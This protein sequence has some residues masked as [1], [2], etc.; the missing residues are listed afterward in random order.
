MNIIHSPSLTLTFLGGD[1]EAGHPAVQTITEAHIAS[2]SI[3]FHQQ[4]LSGLKSASNQVDLLLD[5][6]CPAIEDI[7]ATEGDVKAVLVDGTET[8][9]TGY[10]ST[11]YNWML[12]HAGKQALAITIEDTG[13]RLF[14]KAFIESG[15]HLFNCTASE[16]IEAI[17]ARACITAS[18]DC[19]SLT[20]PVTRSVDGSVTCGELLDQLVYELGHVYFFDA[21]GQLRL[22]KVDCTSTEALPTLDKDDLVVVGGKAIT[23]SKKIRQ[24]KSAR[25]SFTRLGTANGYLVY[26]N[27]T[28]RGDGHPYCHLKL[29]GGSHFDGNEIYTESEW[30]EAQTDFFRTP[31]L[32]E[33]CNATS[34]I[35]IVGS[36]DIIAVSN[37]RTE[38]TAESG[39]ITADIAAAGGPYL[40]VTAHNSGTLTYHITRLD[41]YADIIYERDVNVVRTADSVY[42]GESSD[43]LLSEELLFVHDRTLAQAHA[44]LLGQFHRH[45]G[46]IYTFFSAVDLR[47][48]SLVRLI[49]DAFSGLNVSVLVTGRTFT[50]ESAAY[51]YEAVGISAFDLSAPAYLEV[52]DRGKNDT[53][54]SPG[55]PGSDGLSY[56]VSIQSSNGSVFRPEQ[57]DTILTCHVYQ[58]TTEITE[59]LDASRFR[60]KRL[61]TDPVDDGRWNT[62]SKAIAH[63][64]IEIKSTDCVGRTVFFCEIDLTGYEA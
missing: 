17:C 21:L 3:T 40:E 58:N 55:P 29:E 63:K 32:I 26:R 16:A 43:N 27:T 50:D 4:L 41:A 12:T 1:L 45:A 53:V 19:I 20:S 7:I 34:E 44:N 30:T 59:A 36:S 64:S 31:S 23:L 48:G 49:D 8:L 5:K 61:S 33:A 15:R 57:V 22:F 25:V 42:E 9:F 54:G 38:F 24:Y 35:D 13:T 37:V 56:T 2:R 51:R 52:L 39:Y 46:S 18:P 14:G 47:C 11:S 28:G 6:D 10:L 62:S 60:W